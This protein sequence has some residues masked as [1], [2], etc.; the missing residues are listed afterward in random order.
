MNSWECSGHKCLVY[1]VQ[2][3]FFYYIQTHCHL[4]PLYT[5]HLYILFFIARGTVNNFPLSLNQE[6]Q[7]IHWD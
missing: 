4:K 7:L 2:D 1:N 5:G 6:D 3:Q